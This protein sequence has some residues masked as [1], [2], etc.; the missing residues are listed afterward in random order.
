MKLSKK[1][2]TSSKITFTYDRPPGDV[3]GYLYHADGKQVSRTFKPDDLE[4]TFGK[5]AS[6]KY[7]VEAVGF[8]TIARAEWP[9]TVVEPPSAGDK[10]RYR[11]PGWN[12]GDPTLASSFPGYTVRQITGPG[13]VN[14]TNGTDYYLELGSLSFSASNRLII[15][16]GR[17]VVLV[18]GEITCTN[19]ASDD[20]DAGIQI[21]GGTDGATVHIEGL[22]FT[23]L[24]NGFTIR[25]PRFIQLQNIRAHVR[26][27][28][29]NFNLGHPDLIQVWTPHKC[30]GIRVH[31]FSGYSRFTFF[32]DFTDANYNVSPGFWELHDVDLHGLPPWNDPNG[33]VDGLNCW[34]GYSSVVTWR[35]SNCWFETT[36][37]TSGNRRVLGSHVRQYSGG[38]PL[39][40]AGYTIYD[41]ND[42]PLFTAPLNFNGGS[43]GDIGRTQGHRLRYTDDPKQPN[44]ELEWRCHLAPTSAGADANG[45]FAAASAGADYVSP[46]YQ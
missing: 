40:H 24:P 44:M 46:G 18:G 3:E 30:P 13:T 43:P 14:L 41:A 39:A 4:V 29:D 32:C 25:T 21:D 6:G 31:K 11:P 33:R 22:R 5:V 38:S 37:E 34:M 10:L 36:Y 8:D 28:Q 7:A 15:N 17:N 9:A 2:E 26:I 16:G 27:Y 12:G 45:N 42:Q 23:N 35:G 1:S 19:S 20:G